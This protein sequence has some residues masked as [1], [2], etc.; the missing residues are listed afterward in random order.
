M[1][2]RLSQTLK[3]LALLT[4]TPGGRGCDPSQFTD[5]KH[6]GTEMLSNLPKVAELGS[7]GAGDL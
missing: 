6:R 1:R 4:V 5:K 3:D 7:G 2:P